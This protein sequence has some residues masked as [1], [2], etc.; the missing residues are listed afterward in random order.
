[1]NTLARSVL[2][3]SAVM[4]AIAGTLAMGR[5]TPPVH[6]FREKPFDRALDEDMAT[7]A[8]TSERMWALY[9]PKL[10]QTKSIQPID[11][12]IE[13]VERDPLM[14][15]LVEPVPPRMPKRKAAVVAGDICARHGMRR[16]Y[17]GPRWRCRK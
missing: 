12:S 10:V 15:N 2:I 8:A 17:D 7:M 9:R 16:V 3:G 13:P 14:V 4:V 1:M 11:E 5:G 6:Q